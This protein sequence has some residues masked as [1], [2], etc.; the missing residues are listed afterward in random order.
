MTSILMPENI[1]AKLRDQTANCDL[2]LA[3][4]CCMAVANGMEKHTGSG[5]RLMGL[6]TAFLLAAEAAGL[7]PSD[8][9]AYARNCINT[10][11]GKRPEFAAASDYI[12]QEVI[13]HG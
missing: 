1:T 2:R 8:L 6:A 7:P 12:T 10:A 4:R 9:M 13:T 11:E 5:T 3:A